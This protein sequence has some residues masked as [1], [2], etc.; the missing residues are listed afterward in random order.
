MLFSHLLEPD[1]KLPKSEAISAANIM[2]S[3]NSQIEA[4]KKNDT[5][6]YASLPHIAF[7]FI[8]NYLIPVQLGEVVFFL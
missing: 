5:H 3:L 6:E 4:N 7:L 1:Q 2:E 8:S